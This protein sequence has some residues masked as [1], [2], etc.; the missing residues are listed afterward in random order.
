MKTIKTYNDLLMLFRKTSFV[1]PPKWEDIHS[2]DDDDWCPYVPQGSHLGDTLIVMDDTYEGSGHDAY[3]I[4][5]L[6]R[7]FMEGKIREIHE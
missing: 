7:L 4:Q 1:D 2:C 6:I 3:F 5:E